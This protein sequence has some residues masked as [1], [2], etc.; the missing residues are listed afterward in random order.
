MRKLHNLEF[1]GRLPSWLQSVV[2]GRG[3]ELFSLLITQPDLDNNPGSEPSYKCEK[4]FFGLRNVFFVLSSRK[5]LFF[6]LAA[7]VVFVFRRNLFVPL[8]MV[9]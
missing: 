5:K 3:V 4:Q 8:W 6:C 1:P 2:K 9:A 7:S